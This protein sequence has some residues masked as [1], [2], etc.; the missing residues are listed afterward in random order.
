MFQPCIF[1]LRASLIASSLLLAATAG[2]AQVRVTELMFEGSG[3]AT[4]ELKA[5][6]DFNPK[7]KGEK[8]EFFEITNLGSSTVDVRGW[9]YNDDKTNDPIAFGDAFGSLA[10]GESALLTEVADVNAFRTHWGLSDAVKVYSFG[11]KSNLGKNDSIWLF[12]K[13]GQAVDQVSY[14]VGF[15]AAG[16]SFN[17]TVAALAEP[18]NLLKQVQPGD[19]PDDYR[20]VLNTMLWAASSAGDTFGSRLSADIAFESYGVVVNGQIEQRMETVA[21]HDFANPGSF[22]VSAVPEVSS[23]ALMALGL[24]GLLGIGASRKRRLR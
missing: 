19:K 15:D 22:S 24:L 9:T 14:P 21:R 17:L 10:A 4:V 11:G 2:Q 18:V 16:K 5:N 8:R 7:I 20:G 1:A 6:G 12:N 23:W 13:A 3:L